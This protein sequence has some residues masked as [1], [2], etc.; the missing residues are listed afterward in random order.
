MKENK[1]GYYQS[2]LWLDSK[3]ARELIKLIAG[4]ELSEAE[5]VQAIMHSDFRNAL[6]VYVDIGVSDGAIDSET[7][8]PIFNDLFGK[9]RIVSPEFYRLID[10]PLHLFIY[11]PAEHRPNGRVYLPSQP[12]HG[13]ISL[14]YCDMDGK[15]FGS[16]S[17][18]TESLKPNYPVY[19]S[20]HQVEQWAKNISG[21][22]D[23]Q[24]LQDENQRLQQEVEALKTEV[25]RLQAESL[26]AQ[27]S[28]RK[29]ALLLIARALELYQKGEP[30]RRTQT[31]YVIDILEGQSIHGLGDTT[32]NNLLASAKKVIA[33][34]RNT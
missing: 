26:T 31:A 14:E 21:N 7:G 4:I 25:E 33:E 6:E 19:F 28:P 27:D 13:K 2:L 34:A 16:C 17:V 20:R 22:L 30:Q 32:I 24:E 11:H 18:D 5:L 23:T 12:R 10:S 1:L 29:S 3:G 9:Q 15:K 8:L